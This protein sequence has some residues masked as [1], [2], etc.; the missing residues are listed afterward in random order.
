LARWRFA[1]K[2]TLRRS[3]IQRRLASWPKWQRAATPPRR[4]V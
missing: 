1:E 4:S 3:A 2:S